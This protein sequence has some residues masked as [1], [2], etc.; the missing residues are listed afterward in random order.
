MK[1]INENNEMNIK[2]ELKYN[3]KIYK[4]HFYID[5]DKLVIEIESDESKYSNKYDFENLKKF[6]YFRQ[7]EN[8]DESLEGLN[9]LFNKPF[10]IQE[11][12]NNLEL[13]FPHDKFPIKFILNQID[14]NMNISYDNLS[15]QM[16]KIID[17]NELILG[18]DLGTT[19]SCASVMIDKNIIMIRNSLGS[20]TTPSF[21][22]FLN[23]NEVDVGVMAKLL[24]SNAKNIVYNVKRLIGKSIEQ[25]EIKELMRSLPFTLKNDEA[26]NTLKIELNFHK[27]ENNENVDDKPSDSKKSK[28]KKTEEEIAKENEEKEDFYPEEIC[29]LILKKIIQDSEF[30]LSKK[31]GKEIKIKKS[32]ITVPAYFNQKQREATLNSAKIIGLN[33]EAMINEPTAASLAYGLNSKGNAEKKIIVI[34]FG[35]GTLDITLLKYVKDKNGI[36]CDVIE[37]YGNTDFGGED[38]DKILMAKCKEKFL[39]NKSNKINDTLVFKEKLNSVRLKRACERAKIKLSKFEETK[40]HLENYVQYQS[41]DFLL[42]KEQFIE[43]SKD[44]FIKFE[45][46]LEDFLKKSKTDKN[47][48]EEVILIGGSTFIPKIKEIITNKFNRSKINHHLNPKEVVAMGAAIKGAIDSKLSSIQEIKLF[49]VTNLSLGIKEKDINFNVLIKRSSKIPCEKINVYQTMA[50]NQTFV[51]IEIY[52]GEDETINS[53]NNLLL[54]KFKLVGLPKKKKVMSKFQ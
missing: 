21:I 30:Y 13:L 16:K 19:Y 26:T 36:Y 22:A 10:S 33:V 41:F 2:K 45:K 51:S 31:I 6:R 14:D 37:T 54:G 24:P 12:E 1:E 15:P 43:Y 3:D 49:D 23:K 18:I 44:L 32:V 17:D 11:K 40:I 53:E 46:I 29:S 39:D 34:D 27:D 8:L 5:G 35:G 4:A 48:I 52:E 28:N 25:K 7:Y 42:T 47:L 38:F 20:T 50:D 9:D